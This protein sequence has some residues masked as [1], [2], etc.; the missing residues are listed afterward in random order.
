M[1]SMRTGKDTGKVHVYTKALGYVESFLRRSGG[2]TLWRWDAVLEYIGCLAVIL[3]FQ[4][5]RTD[6]I[7]EF[8]GLVLVN[9]KKTLLTC[10]C[11]LCNN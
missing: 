6:R 11:S 1:K 4:P 9:G 7:E 3:L 2:N 8:D 5:T 10:R